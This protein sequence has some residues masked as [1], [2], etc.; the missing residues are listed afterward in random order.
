MTEQSK[1]LKE[2]KNELNMIKAANVSYD[3]ANDS[4]LNVST[5]TDAKIPLPSKKKQPK[6]T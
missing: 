6:T 2:L 5:A 4:K 1:K 3:S